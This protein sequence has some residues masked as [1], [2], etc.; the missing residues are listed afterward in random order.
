MAYNLFLINKE[1][2]FDVNSC[3]LR[4]LK[5]DG[6]KVTLNAPTARCLQLLIENG[7]KVVSRD[8]FLERV[9]MVRGIVVSQNTFYQNIS[10][11]RKSLKKAG[12][13]DEIIVTVRRNGFILAP[14]THLEIVEEEESE[15]SIP[16]TTISGHASIKSQPG[17]LTGYNVM[18]NNAAPSG[19]SGVI[20]K[21][22][23]WV[24]V[25]FVILIVAELIS[26]FIKHF[27]MLF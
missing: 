12:L 10:L 19:S 16:S 6:T 15:N 22:P 5:P 23:K 1:I 3:E 7:G 24:I 13:T 21:L 27:K 17:A 14:G 18:D 4:T 25:L 20:L 9:W 26:L 8:D 2:I 11:L